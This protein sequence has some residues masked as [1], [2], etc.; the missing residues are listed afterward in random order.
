MKDAFTPEEQAQFRVVYRQIIA[1][2][3]AAAPSALEG[4]HDKARMARIMKEMESR[5]QDAVDGVIPI[6][7]AFCEHR[8]APVPAVVGSGVMTRE[9]VEDL[10]VLATRSLSMAQ[11]SLA[12]MEDTKRAWLARATDWVEAEDFLA[13]MEADTIERAAYATKE[14]ERYREMLS[15]PP[16]TTWTLTGRTD[17]AQ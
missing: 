10:Y 11:S 2:L 13:K 5:L 14:V 9:Q 7:E 4:L 16:G 17:A 1:S 6:D 3:R 12:E 8:R 15:A